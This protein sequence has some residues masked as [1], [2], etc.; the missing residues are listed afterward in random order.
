MNA[1]T[2]HTIFRALPLDEQKRLYTLI[3][4]DLNINPKKRLPKTKIQIIS[5]EEARSYL[6]TKIFKVKL[7]KS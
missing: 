6:L 2:V 4:K 5:D 7:K 3:Q 1:E